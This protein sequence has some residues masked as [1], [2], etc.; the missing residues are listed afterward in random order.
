MKTLIV[1]PARLGSTRLPEK[2]LLSETGKTLIE[3]TYLAAVASRY[4]DRVIV[5][6]DDQRIVDAVTS[7]GGMAQMTDKNHQS[8]TDR[9]AEVASLFPEYELV[10]NV[11]GDEPELET[12]AIDAAIEILLR[13]PASSMS[14]VAA[15]ILDEAA[16]HDPA[17][18]KVVLRHDSIALYFSRSQIPFPRN[19][20]SM[21]GGQF[22]W[23][24]HMGLYVYRRQFLLDYSS[25]PASNLEKMESLEQLRAVENGHPIAV[26]LVERASRG[27]DT[28]ED[29]RA[30]VKRFLAR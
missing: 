28:P 11:Q 29:Y 9:V 3:H 2:M 10:V 17:C 18:V 25:L 4:A 20:D 1:I 30:F 13:T 24:Q 6:T 21:S 22:A 26:A 5:A 7:F 19:M 23:L 14:T 16:F 12:V 15:P 27:I 8:G